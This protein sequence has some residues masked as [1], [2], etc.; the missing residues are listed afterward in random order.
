VA[1]VF[2]RWGS[3]RDV[4]A[5]SGISKDNEA[6]MTFLGF[7]VLYDPLKPEIVKTIRDLQQLGI[8]LKIIT[9]DNQFV[10]A[11]ASQQAGR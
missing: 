5:S 9:G 11:H 10:A 4:G 7:L 3:Y 1:K 2:G 6:E 8:S